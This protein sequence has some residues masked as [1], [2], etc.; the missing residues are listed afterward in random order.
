M[1]TI[2]TVPPVILSTLVSPPPLRPSTEDAFGVIV[3]HGHPRGSLKFMSTGGEA[4][5]L[6]SWRDHLSMQ[7]FPYCLTGVDKK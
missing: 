3:E 6:F 4:R 1:A 7:K 2:V 5:T